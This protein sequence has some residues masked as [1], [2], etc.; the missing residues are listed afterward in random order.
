MNTTLTNDNLPNTL[1]SN[2]KNYLEN[3]KLMTDV[4]TINDGYIVN[5]GVMFDVMLEK[6]GR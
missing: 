1:T 5:F 2:I 4:V 3:F 6:Y